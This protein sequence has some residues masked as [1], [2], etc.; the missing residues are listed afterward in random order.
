MQSYFEGLAGK[1]DEEIRLAEAA[2]HIAAEE[3]PEVKIL[4]YLNLLQA[5]S[6]ALSRDST[7]KSPSQQIQAINELMFKRMRFTGN[8]ENYYDPK[9]SFLNDV[10]DRRT[11][12]PITLSVI[13]LELAWSL[14]LDAVGIGFPGH[15]LVRVNTENHALYVDPFH[16]GNIMTVEGCKEFWEDLTEGESEFDESF[17]WPVDKRQILSRMLRNLKG[18]YLEQKGYK[19]LVCILDMI[20]SLNPDSSEEIRDRGIIYY[21]TEAFRFALKDFETFLSMSPDAEDA[22]VI[23]QYIEVLRD[24]SSRLN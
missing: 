4:S 23:R 10:M 6:A 1:K 22:E 7:R 19:K 5:W 8:V 13:Y 11:G 17:L 2:L 16:K 3:Y 21:Q 20:I 9:N 12:I 15:F 18:I 24:Y 14:G